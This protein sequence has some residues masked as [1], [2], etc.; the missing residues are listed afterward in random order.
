MSSLAATNKSLAESFAFAFTVNVTVVPSGVS[1]SGRS[2]D[3][4]ALDLPC[5]YIARTLEFSW[6]SRKRPT[7]HVCD[8]IVADDMFAL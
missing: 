8:I 5:V 7:I 1:K 2:T 6:N 4:S 3:I